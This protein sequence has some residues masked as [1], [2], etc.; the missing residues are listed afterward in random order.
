[1][2]PEQGITREL[3]FGEVFSKT[4]ELYQRDFVK[5]FVIFAVVEV[6]IGIV[7]AVAQNAF[8]LPTLPSNPTSQQVFDWFP[9]FFGALV[10]LLASILLV[11]V[12]FYPIAQGSTI[13]LASEQVEKGQADI[14]ASVRFAASRLL[15]IWALS[16]VV[17]IIVVLGFIAL[18]IPGIILA[19]M[20]TL[21]FPVLIIENKGVL[22]SMGR[23]RELVSHRWLKTFGTFL[24]FGIIFIIASVI[25]SAISGLFGIAS[26]VVNGVLSAFYQPIFPILLV[27]YFYSNRA[28]T[29]SG[30]AGQSSMASAMMAP[31]GMKFCPNCGAQLES[32]VTF[33]SKCGAKQP[34]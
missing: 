14:W 3:S 34:A 2:A 25:V 33:C 24:V 21:A 19:I 12:V 13:K 22:E 32:S 31:P 16:I 18:I 11:S 23:S 6:I 9:R 8:V 15:W 10:P 1:M 26:P 29:S 17:G 28:R 7:T 5:Y 4:F 20:F 30:Q 27:V